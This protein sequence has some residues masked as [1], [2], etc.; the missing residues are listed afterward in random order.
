[1]TPEYQAF[2]KDAQA[3]M[4]KAISFLKDEFN[5]L[6][7]G[8][9]SIVMVEDI[10][11]DAYG[12]PSNIKQN[13]AISVPDP[14]Q[15]VVEPWDKSLLKDIEKGIHNSGMDFS[16]T[17][18]GKV[19]RISIPSL[20]EERKKELVKYAKGIAEDA[21]VVIRNARRDINSKL[22]D[23]AKEIS[24]DDMRK[25]LDKIQKETDAQIAIIDEAMKSKEKDIMTV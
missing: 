22:K 9:A 19:L 15:I 7:A 2:R 1:M 6:K 21:K 12:Q 3:G 13:A 11:F 25:E 17:N 10:T 14:H 8:R 5:R 23:I 4:D 16:V 18:D 20:T 24:E